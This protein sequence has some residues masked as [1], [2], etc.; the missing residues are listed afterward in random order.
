[1]HQAYD[2]HFLCT[3]ITENI[4]YFLATED[5]LPDNNII[6]IMNNKISN[7]ENNDHPIFRA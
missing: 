3:I 1:M 6:R 2:W 4:I 7:S 5:F